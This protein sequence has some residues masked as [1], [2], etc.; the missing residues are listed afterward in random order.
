[1]LARNKHSS[2]FVPL[3]SYEEKDDTW[4]FYMGSLGDKIVAIEGL[5]SVACIIKIL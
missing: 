5:A 4:E 3:G 2:L 1:M